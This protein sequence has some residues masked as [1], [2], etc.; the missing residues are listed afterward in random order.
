MLGSIPELLTGDQAWL[1]T[2][3]DELDRFYYHATIPRVIE[4]LYNFQYT[5]STPDWK[6]PDAVLTEAYCYI[7]PRETPR[8]TQPIVLTLTPPPGSTPYSPHAPSLLDSW[9][10]SYSRTVSLRR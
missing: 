5:H 10:A 2:R 1:Q 8:E 3:H 4:R 9:W 6:F 7:K